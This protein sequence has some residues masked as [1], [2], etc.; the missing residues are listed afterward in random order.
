[1]N[2][3]KIREQIDFIDTKLI[4][5]FNE[6]LELALRTRNYKTKTADK[7]REIEVIRRIRSHSNHLIEP[8]F[9]EK[10]F[11]RIIDESKRV[12]DRKP[13]LIGFQGAHGAY[14]E[15]AVRGFDG[16]AIPIPCRHF[17]DVFDSVENG[18]IDL[19][20][21]PVEN[22][23]AGQ[24]AA[25][26]DLLVERDL[27]IVAEA[28]VPVHHALLCRRE[29]DP[30]GLRFVYSHPVA[31]AQCEGMI[32]RRG[33]EPQ[34]HYDTAGAAKTLM[35]DP[36]LRMVGVIASKLCADLYDLQLVEE[37]VED[38]HRNSTRFVI[39]AREGIDAGNKTS[40]LFS[41]PNTAGSLTDILRIFSD[42]SI[43]LTRI[44]SRPLRGRPDQYGFLADLEG[45]AQEA[46]VS[47]ALDL[48]KGELRI[49]KVLGTYRKFEEPAA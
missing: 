31:L 13:R 18:E 5:L 14:S 30:E 2:L 44:E 41:T 35:S 29:V 32:Q 34:P 48:L 37:N 27:K 9:A 12:Q 7:S 20:M 38:D 26:N 3:D 43:N 45:G 23:L 22:N 8:D 6:R 42:R 46:N 49:F 17:K 21:I 33:L 39:V 19:G 28:K 10:I 1:M 24:I 16:D 40:I 4:H 15:V 47:E 11:A 36:Q 25:A